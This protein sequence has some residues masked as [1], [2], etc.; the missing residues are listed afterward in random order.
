MVAVGALF[1][2]TVN[3]AVWPPAAAVTMASRLVVSVVCASPFT[4]VMTV[5]FA[6][7]P[8]SAEKETGTPGSR[9]PL[10]SVTPADSWTVPPADGTAPGLTL[11]TMESAAAPPI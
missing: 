10:A 9:L 4:L 1:T 8:A 2:R 5:R 3:V 11:R 7:V 6:S